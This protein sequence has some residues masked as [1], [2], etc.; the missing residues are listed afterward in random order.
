LRQHKEA[1]P[2]FILLM[3]LFLLIHTGGVTNTVPRFPLANGSVR[4]LLS[5]T[6]NETIFKR[7]KGKEET[8][9]AEGGNSKQE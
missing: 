6:V 3:L 8:I 1:K 7:K 9:A 4:A 5:K 2:F